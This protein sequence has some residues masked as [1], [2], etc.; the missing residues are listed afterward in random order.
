[1]AAS[2]NDYVKNF[3]NVFICLF[4]TELRTT[5]MTDSKYFTTNKKG[6]YDREIVFVHV[7]MLEIENLWQCIYKQYCCQ[8]FI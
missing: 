3:L 2:L 1:M 5:I 4:F 6:E 7:G 8:L